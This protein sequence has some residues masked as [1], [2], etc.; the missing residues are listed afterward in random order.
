MDDLKQNVAP[1][2]PLT[3]L[4]WSVYRAIRANTLAGLDP[5]TQRQLV[6]LVNADMES[7]GH[8]ERLAYNEKDYN[9]CRALHTICNDLNESP[10]V[11][12]PISIRKYTYCLGT[13]EED[14]R[15][16]AKLIRDG[17]RKLRRASIVIN[18]I[19]KH[20]QGKLVD[21]HGKVL[22]SEDIDFVE[23]FIVNES[24]PSEQQ[25]GDSNK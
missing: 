17:K 5:L 11:E 4:H 22:T 25:E 24:K 1:S 16:A 23:A 10:Q 18:K 13:Q 6:D 8:K 7:M 2:D 14:E 3:P 21:C 9:H 15:Y 19:K 12:K 20:G